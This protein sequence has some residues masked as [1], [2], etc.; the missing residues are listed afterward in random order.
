MQLRLREASE[1]RRP[2]H[3]RR[4]LTVRQL[5]VHVSAVLEGNKLEVGFSLE[6]FVLH[7]PLGRQKK[8]VV[9][10]QT[11]AK[12]DNASHLNIGK[13]ERLYVHPDSVA[14][15]YGLIEWLTLEGHDG[16]V[17]VDGA[18]ADSS[19][20]E[21]AATIRELHIRLL[22]SSFGKDFDSLINRLEVIHVIVDFFAIQ[23]HGRRA[24]LFLEAGHLQVFGS[25]G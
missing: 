15:H 2:C 5:D 20:G 1:E 10:A 11:I 8:V 14:L 12:V 25:D 22:A 4:D 18:P 23:H 19:Y 9:V 13:R 24:G 21:P 7:F 17:G 3:S 16:T 6:Q